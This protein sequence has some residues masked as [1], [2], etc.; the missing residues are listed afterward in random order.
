MKNPYRSSLPRRIAFS[1]LFAVVCNAQTG[2]GAWGVAAR[3]TDLFVASDNIE[4]NAPQSVLLIGENHA[5]VKTQ[6]QLK[7]FLEQLYRARAIDAILVEGSNGEIRASDLRDRLPD[8][9]FTD[10]FWKGQLSLGQIAGYEYI[11][12]TRDAVRVWGVEDMDAKR[13]YTVDAARREVKTSLEDEVT[14]HNRA[15]A[16]AKDVA[17][18]VDPGVRQRAGLDTALASY[19]ST[20]RK[21]TTAKDKDGS[22]YA[23]AE[24]NY[25]DSLERVTALYT[26]LRAVLPAY[27]RLAKVAAPYEK[28]LERARKLSSGGSLSPDADPAKLL[29]DLQAAKNRVEKASTDFDAASKQAGYA[30]ANAVVT[31]LKQIQDYEEKLKQSEQELTT[32]GTQFRALE[33]ELTDRFFLAANAA[34][35]AKGQPIPA[36]QTF[37]RDEREKARANGTDPE[38]PFLSDRDQHMVANTLGYLRS[39]QNVRT[40]ALIIGYAHL[41]GMTNRLRAQNINLLAGKIASSEEETEEWENRAWERRRRPPVAIFARAEQNKELSLLLDDT[42]KKEIPALLTKLQSLNVNGSRPIS[43]GKTNIFEVSGA[44]SGR[45]A[46]VVTPDAAALRA[47]WGD[48]VL[49]LGTLPDGSGKHYLIVDRD[50]AREDAKNLSTATTLF[51]SA[52]RTA[53][54]QGAATNFD[55][56]GATVGMSAFKA[57]PPTSKGSTPN[58]IVIAAEGDSRALNTALGAGGNGAEP[59]WTTRVARFAEPPEGRKPLIFFTKNMR[60]AK[61]RLGS[62]D[63]QDALRIG[64]I[65]SIE[66]GLNGAEGKTSL[67]DLWFTPERGDHA[68]AYLIAGDNTAEFRQK[69]KEAADAGLLRNKQIALASCFDPNETDA[70]RDMLLDAGALMVWAPENRISPETARKLRGYMEKVDT[71]PA[72]AAPRGL[73][74][75]MDRALGLWYKD[76]KNDPDLL[77][78]LNSTNTAEVRPSD[79]AF[80]NLEG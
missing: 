26:K 17:A 25:E 75:Y 21:F 79:Q 16:L 48:Q 38:K 50:R 9:K 23:D 57:R 53:G 13:R 32:F 34:R 56:A 71:T 59:P 77:P 67:D 70:L 3:S 49:G 80:S 27:D 2:S 10:E 76:A 12:L 65:A 61:E 64:Q 60:R 58:R 18:Q 47:D 1:A 11:A 66:I 42:Y 19:E 69:I 14:R 68:R 78:L 36:L 51:A 55:V 62:I 43:L 63:K 41:E 72:V 6:T 24:A 22:R 20:I 4:K 74:E 37:L 39:N 40:V 8:G 35:S 45:K 5:S 31:D 44:T 30:D 52:Y 7:D 54:A 73:D 46:I 28:L 15:L 29:A 33:N